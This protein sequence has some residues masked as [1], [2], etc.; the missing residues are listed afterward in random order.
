MTVTM[1]TASSSRVGQDDRLLVL[2]KVVLSLW[3]ILLAI[4]WKKVPCFFDF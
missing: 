3:V 1:G 2:L 4:F